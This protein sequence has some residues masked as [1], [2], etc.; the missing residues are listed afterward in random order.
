MREITPERSGAARSRAAARAIALLAVM[1]A[2]ASG[3][4]LRAANIGAREMSADEGASWAS[5]IAPTLGEVIRRQATLNPGKLATHEIILHEWI[6]AFGDGLAAMRALSALFG[7]T[8]I[9]IVYALAAELM[10]M[11]GGAQIA[12]DQTGRVGELRRG[13]AVGITPLAITKIAAFAALLFAVS[14][15]TIKY[16]R[17]MRMYALLMFVMLAQVWMLL[18]AMRLGGA[19]DLALAAILTA[20]GVATNFTA[21]FVIA[22][23]GL[24]IVARFAGAWRRGD[25]IGMRAMWRTALALGAGCAMLAPFAAAAIRSSAGAL[26]AGATSWIGRPQWWEPVAMFNKGIGTFAFPAVAAAAGWGAWRGWQIAPR[27]IGFALLWMWGPPLMMLAASY[28]IAPVFIERY[29]LTSF[30]PFLILAA[31]G[32]VEIASRPMRAA[33]M[34]LLIALALGHVYTYNQNPHDAQWH[35]AAT[36]AAAAIAPGGR[37]AVAPPYAVNVV[38]YYL[39]GDAVHSEAAIPADARARGASIMIVAQGFRRFDVA[40]PHP[41]AGAAPLVR[42]RGIEVVRLRG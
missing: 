29:A 10:R 30:I 5:A 38:R 18:R 24:W 19:I 2:L 15:I 42:L 13:A 21:V 26:R 36:I 14:L 25:R 33:A 32:A 20:L 23:E 7:I 17:E 27:A 35:E 41:S 6:G 28:A 37:I 39:R 34:G 1:L 12:A 40:G 9:L 3:G 4:Y 8:A 22:T 31:I 11:D 16:S